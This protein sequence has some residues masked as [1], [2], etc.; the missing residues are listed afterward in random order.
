MVR[1]AC[2]SVFVL[3]GLT[4][5]VTAGDPDGQPGCAVMAPGHAECGSGWAAGNRF[6]IRAE[7]ADGSTKAEWRYDFTGTR[8]LNLSVTFTSSGKTETGAVFLID[9]HTML[10]N[11]LTLQ[12]G[13]EI[14]T[15]GVP[16]LSLQLVLDL[17]ERRFPGGPAAIDGR[18]SFHDGDDAR[19]LNVSARGAKAYI[20]APWR[21]TGAIERQ[22][23]ARIA[24]DLT[25]AFKAMPHH[26][27]EQSMQ[28][29]GTWERRA[30]PPNLPD[31]TKI[32]GWAIHRITGINESAPG[33][34]LHDVQATPISV[35][36]PTLGALRKHIAATPGLAEH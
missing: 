19:G 32:E 34:A 14:E 23:G 33:D 18:S 9:D 26:T 4:G 20:P 13:R 6:V 22:A 36:F 35:S 11:G 29:S 31:N 17:L 3:L 15:L 2:F 25:L 8:D 12:A 5:P 10:T 1:L 21:M 24:F 27:T 7:S 16:V 28:F 30:A